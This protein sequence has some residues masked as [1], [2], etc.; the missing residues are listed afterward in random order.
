MS[1]IWLALPLVATLAT[2]GTTASAAPARP[3]A[4]VAPPSRLIFHTLADGQG[5][6][7][8]APLTGNGPVKRLFPSNGEPLAAVATR[9][10][11]VWITEPSNPADTDIVIA[12][13]N[14]GGERV[15]VRH[16]AAAP[17]LTRA[18]RYVYWGGPHWIGRVRL[19]GT[20]LRRFFIRIPI[21]PNS[22]SADGMTTDGQY[23]Y[24]TQCV[25]GRIG[26]V[27]IAPSGRAPGVH[28]LVMDPGDGGFCPQAVAYAN[29]HLFYA[30]DA[31]IGRITTDGA[32]RDD[33]VAPAEIVRVCVRLRY[34]ERTRNSRPRS[35][36]SGGM[37]STA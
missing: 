37:C 17:V 4:H 30:D 36:T 22:G 13:Q 9:Q 15:L 3:A 5:A 23:L 7:A 34:S 12:N 8:Q 18:G 2:A 6:W 35:L 20:H 19:D 25:A 16:V 10:A 28:W 24:F 29:G 31:G 33:T 11:I 27:P 14:G 32:G 1:R 21:K 26:R